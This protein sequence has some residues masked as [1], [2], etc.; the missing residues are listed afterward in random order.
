MEARCADDLSP[1]P[2]KDVILDLFQHFTVHMYMRE[3]AVH[4]I[5]FLDVKDAR[6]YDF[7]KT[8]DARMNELERTC[9]LRNRCVCKASGSLA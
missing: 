3:G 6:F 2:P 8:L 1:L 5:N 9:I 7:R 4:D